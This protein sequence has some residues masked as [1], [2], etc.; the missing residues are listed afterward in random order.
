MGKYYNNQKCRWTINRKRFTNV[1]IKVS[2]A[3]YQFV[4]PQTSQMFPFQITHLDL[5]EQTS[6]LYDYLGVGVVD[7][8]VTEVLNQ[9]PGILTYCQGN[10]SVMG[11][12]MELEYHQN[13]YIYFVSDRSR[14]GT[15]FTIE[16]KLGCRSFDYIMEGGPPL[17]AEITSPGWPEGYNKNESCFWG[18]ILGSTRQLKVTAEL[19]IDGSDGS[20]GGDFILMVSF[21]SRRES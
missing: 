6:C 10:S 7:Y 17:K 9:P 2:I 8:T 3:P 14:S 1:E 12:P 21:F 15:G 16:Y 19:D 13:V 20:C 18:I 4:P 11:T 5:E